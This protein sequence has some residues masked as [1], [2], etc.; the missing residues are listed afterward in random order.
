MA[1]QH[2]CVLVNGLWGWQRDWHS[3][4]RALDRHNDDTLLIHVSAVNVGPQTYAGT[5]RPPF[6][7]QQRHLLHSL[8]PHAS[9]AT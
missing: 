5:A 7:L 2:C 6:A 1:P 3:L 9:R 8:M 4:R